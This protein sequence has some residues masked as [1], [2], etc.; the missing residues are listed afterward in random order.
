M[1]CGA[2]LD[3]SHIMSQI[4]L[5]LGCCLFLFAALSIA[6]DKPDR[7]NIVLIMS[8]DMGYSDIGC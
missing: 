7:P 8:D 3:G 5:V 1:E 6:A 2:F 4:R